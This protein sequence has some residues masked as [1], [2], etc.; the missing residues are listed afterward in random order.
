MAMDAHL[1]AQPAPANT[2]PV[3]ALAIAATAA[4]IIL[5]GAAF[6]LSY[7]HL[8]QV[9][10]SNGMHDATIRSWAWPATIDLFIVIGE[11]LI[12][13]ASLAHRVDWWAIALAV[14]GSGGSIA[15]NVAG[16]G[17][18]A[19]LLDYIVAAVPPVAA[20]LAFGALMRQVHEHLV[21]IAARTTD[22]TATATELRTA[23]E[24]PNATPVLVAT[25]APATLIAPPHAPG[26]A[27][28]APVAASTPPPPVHAPAPAPVAATPTPA[29]DTV[30]PASTSSKTTATRPATPLR[31]L[32]ER[33]AIVAA[34]VAEHG[35]DG[36]QKVLAD[37]LGG[38]HKSTASRALTKWRNRNREA[39]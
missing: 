31:T 14:L 37:A 1:S 29:S 30:A 36:P 38:V 3:I 15:L 18:N 16:V 21:T 6:W 2:G 4:S 32:A 25:P 28:P 12:L 22:T 27:T 33:D 24:S 35:V 13:R 26:N 19:G 20:L 5:T 9:A 10:A 8:H 11:L 7:D 17:A 23:P 34:F 39:S